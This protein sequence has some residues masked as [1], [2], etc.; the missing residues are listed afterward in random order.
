[1]QKIPQNKKCEKSRDI[2]KELANNTQLSISILEVIAA[3]L[4]EIA[5]EQ[6]LT[7][8]FKLHEKKYRIVKMAEELE[9]TSQQVARNFDRLSEAGIVKRDINRYYYLTLFGN[10]IYEQIL[11]SIAFM[12]QNKTYFESH[13]LGGIPLKFI[14]RIGELA[15]SRIVSGNSKVLRQRYSIYKNAQK[16]IYHNTEDTD[17]S[18]EIADILPGKL[19]NNV[20][21][22]LIFSYDSQSHNS[23]D[24]TV[25]EKNLQKF[26]DNGSF[27]Q[28][29][30]NKNKKTAGGIVIILNEKEAGI[31]FPSNNNSNEEANEE[32][33]YNKMLYSTDPMFRDWCLDY[34]K[35]LQE[36]YADL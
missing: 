4:F 27:E 21:I 26:I 1:M 35:Y 20:K 11:P 5:S 32:Q 14:H 8:I 31:I 28:K 12:T 3:E 34:F 10:I 19:E 9:S 30:K 33:D 29:V 25:Q 7:M 6:R 17:Y 2:E 15:N 13:N 22:K 36:D 16:S 24:K 23:R 18:P